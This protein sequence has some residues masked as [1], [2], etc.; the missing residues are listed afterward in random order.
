MGLNT[1]RKRANE[2]SVD[3]YGHADWNADKGNKTASQVLAEINADPSKMGNGGTSGQLYQEIKAAAAAEKR[4]SNNSGGGGYS[5]GGYS[6]GGGGGTIGREGFRKAYGPEFQENLKEAT[7]A[8]DQDE[9]KMGNYEGTSENFQRGMK[10]ELAYRDN[11]PFNDSW[12][13]RDFFSKHLIMGRE[14]QKGR[15]DGT[16][17]TNKYIFNASQTNPINVQALDQQIRTNPLYSE[18]KAELSKLN[19]FGDRYK[20]KG[21]TAAWLNP[22]GPSPYEAPNLENIAKGYMDRI[23]DMSL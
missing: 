2:G 22:N 21:N 20:E 11:D 19:T 14:A 7:K 15:G 4:S 1:S 12:D 8:Y 17:I 3:Y 6:G 5:G 13:S 23:D 10:E 18:A 9:S 16:A